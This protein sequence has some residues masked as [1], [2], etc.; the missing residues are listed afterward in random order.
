M[1]A[2]GSFAAYS[3]RWANGMLS[4]SRLWCT[5]L[6]LPFTCC[7]VASAHDQRFFGLLVDEEDDQAV[8][9]SII[10]STKGGN[11]YAETGCDTGVLRAD[12]FSIAEIPFGFFITAQ[13]T[14]SSE[15]SLLHVKR[16]PS[17]HLRASLRMT[18]PT[19]RLSRRRSR[20]RTPWRRPA[21]TGRSCRPWR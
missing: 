9:L 14:F 2:W 7:C 4:S 20:R 21:S 5:G 1:V 12:E 8:L 10:R 15:G 13:R 17:L 11:W 16:D 6:A 18:I 19:A 3:A